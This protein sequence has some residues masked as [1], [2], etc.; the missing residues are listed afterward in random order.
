VYGSLPPTTETVGPLEKDFV[1]WAHAYETWE[2]V[3]ELR[4][5]RYFVAVADAGQFDR[6]RRAKAPYFPAIS[7][8][9]SVSEPYTHGAASRRK[10][11]Y[12]Q[13]SRR[14]RHSPLAFYRGQKSVCCQV[15]RI[16]RDEF[17]GIE[18]RL[19]SDYSPT[20]AKALMRRKLAPNHR[21]QCGYTDIAAFVRI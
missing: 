9:A 17:P 21:L 2:I 15:N 14:D 12:A 10:R 16:L 5:L 7:R 4:H 6:C 1:S 13:L 11:R 19:S 3:M 20:L 18:I 8:P